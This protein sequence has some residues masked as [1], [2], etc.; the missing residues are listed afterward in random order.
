MNYVINNLFSL[1]DA[2]I[3]LWIMGQADVAWQD[4]H[5]KTTTHFDYEIYMKEC[6]NIWGQGQE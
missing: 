1:Y 5:H 4:E 3:Y 2:G 6:V